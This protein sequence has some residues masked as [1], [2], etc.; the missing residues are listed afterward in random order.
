M[1]VGI[2]RRVLYSF[3]A[4][5]FFCGF[6]RGVAGHALVHPFQHLHIVPRIVRGVAVEIEPKK[7]SGLA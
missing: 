1:A 6:K 2:P 3:R 7:I 5:G 4:Q